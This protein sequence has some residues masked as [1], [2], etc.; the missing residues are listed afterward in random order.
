MV[1]VNEEVKFLWKCKKNGGRGVRSGRG[2]GSRGGGWLIGRGLV[3]MFG[4]GGDVGYGEREP[5][6]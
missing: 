1:D 4:V 3:A 6:K 2:W 5:K